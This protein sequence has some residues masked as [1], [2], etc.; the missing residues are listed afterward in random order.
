MAY[1]NAFFKNVN[2]KFQFSS[3]NFSGQEKEKNPEKMKIGALQKGVLL[4]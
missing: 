2:T 4:L 1:Y 3:K